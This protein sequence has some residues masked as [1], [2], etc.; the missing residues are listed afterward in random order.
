VFEMPNIRE[1]LLQTRSIAVVGLSRNPARPSH[2]VASYLLTHRYRV[3]PVNPNYDQILDQRCYPSLSDIPAT[4]QIDMVNI[5]RRPEA[6]P[7]VVEEAIRIGA[8]T[9]WM[10]VGVIHPQAAEEARQ[11]G[12]TVV[13]DRCLMVE[14]QYYV[15]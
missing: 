15:C 14:H 10:Q 7:G 4:L 3:V 11:A 5:F 12:L 2:E 1:L 9:I 6:V 13:M 8:K